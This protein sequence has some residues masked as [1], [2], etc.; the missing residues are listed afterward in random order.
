[1]WAHYR[2]TALATQIFVV[3]MCALVYFVG[4]AP[5]RSIVTIFIVMQICG[6][7]GAWWGARLRGR[8]E[9]SEN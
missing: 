9:K 1:M 8:I 3:V 6:L 4:N 2:Q 7:L 5:M